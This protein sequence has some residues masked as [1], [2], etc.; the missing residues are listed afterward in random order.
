[1]KFRTGSHNPRN[2]YLDSGNRDTDIHMGVMF[3]PEMATLVVNAVN[4]YYENL[5]DDENE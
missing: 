1:M 2:I 4:K 3:T 5:D